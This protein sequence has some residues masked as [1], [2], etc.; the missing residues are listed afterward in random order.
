MRNED[1]PHTIKNIPYLLKRL[2]KSRLSHRFFGL[3]SMIFVQII[4]DL[5]V[6]SDFYSFYHFACKFFFVILR[7]EVNRRGVLKTLVRTIIAT[8]PILSLNQTWYTCIWVFSHSTL[9]SPKAELEFNRNQACNFGKVT[10]EV[11]FKIFGSS[12]CRKSGFTTNVIV[13]Y[14]ACALYPE[15]TQNEL[16]FSIELKN[17]IQ[18]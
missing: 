15:A 12:C 17:S 14:P 6:L 3:I 18:N 13:L 1:S 2:R 10:S 5:S 7:T 11:E 4:H 9:F 8:I 16:C